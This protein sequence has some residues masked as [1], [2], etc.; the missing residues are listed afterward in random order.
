MKLIIPLSIVASLI[1]I[2]ACNS[3]KKSSTSATKPAVIP[4]AA[5]TSTTA[6]IPTSTV[7]SVNIV[8]STNGI[9]APGNEEL[10]AIQKQY[11][12][13]TLNQL[14]QGYEIY[15]KGACIKCHGAI[16]IYP[17][18]EVQW[19]SVINDMAYRAGISASEKDAVL[20]Y[21]LSIKATQPR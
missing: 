2:T 4:V 3:S 9:Y 5:G 18:E 12:D 20:K 8:K 13:V 14:N 19:G 16:E 17:R 15:T 7:S 21:V 1:I 6:S 11:K 10:I